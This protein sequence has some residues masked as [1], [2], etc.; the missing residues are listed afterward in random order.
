MGSGVLERLSADFVHERARSRSSAVKRG[1]TLRT[2]AAPLRGEWP[3]AA[4]RSAPL[5]LAAALAASL[6]MIA[7]PVAGP[8]WAQ[9]APAPTAL[10]SVTVSKTPQGQTQ[11]LLGFDK[12][13]PPYSIIAND[14]ARPTIA[15][16]GSVRARGASFPTGAGDPVKNAVFDER[17]GTLVLTFSSPS[18]IRLA[19]TPSGERTLALTFTTPTGA[20]DGTAASPGALP[21]FAERGPDQDAFEI[22]P[23]KYAD[24]S[25]VVGLL[26][27]DDSVRPNDTFSPQEPA[28]GSAGMMNNGAVAGPNV[29]NPGLNPNGDIANQAFGHSVND[30][31]G[32]DRRLNAIILRGSPDRI[33]RLKEKIA[34]IDVPVTSVILETV[35]VEL[36]QTG[37]RNVGLD[38]NNTNSQ[39]A[40]ATFDS[41]SYVPYG[42]G[43]IN[44]VRSVALQ[45]AIYAQ[46]QN[47]RGRIISKPRISAQSGAS[48]KIIT[49]DALPI[50]TAITLS[51]VNGV[52]Q[53]VQYV[54]VGVTL[55]IAPRVTDDGF[56]TSHV[57]CEVSSVTGYSQGYPT[58]SQR[59]ASTSATVRDG[60]SFVIG[61]LTEENELSNTGKLPGAGDLPFFG[62]LFQ[63]QTATKSKTEL[64]IVVTPHIVRG[65]DLAEARR[66]RGLSDQPP[67]G[68]AVLGQ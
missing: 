54:T 66:Q 52:S 53:Q 14:D 4:W 11:V 21:A 8:A 45:A 51:G 23:L 26:T 36:T 62:K 43:A 19:A 3:R 15:F 39:I 16:A 37:A 64:Y 1:S 7:A 41:G 5:A 67:P 46:V 63:H 38:F 65:T 35:F 59:E 29:I 57:F 68:A 56:V 24:I 60:E 13:P 48:A 31:I 40:T 2:R 44:G 30:A 9:G 33:A 58:I 18:P 50:L 61:G 47:G 27:S 32:V 25:E 12:A 28:F 49:G 20:G 10:V 17:D 22:V 55:Q 42:A 34:K 6:S